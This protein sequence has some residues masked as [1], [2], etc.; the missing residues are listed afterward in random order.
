MEHDHDLGEYAEPKRLCSHCPMRSD[1]LAR[2][3]KKSM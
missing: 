3:V 1:G 2:E